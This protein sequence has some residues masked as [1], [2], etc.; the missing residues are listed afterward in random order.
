MRNTTQDL[1][2]P[3]NPSFLSYIDN[4]M[5]PL[6]SALIAKGY[7]PYSHCEG[8]T[9]KDRT[10][11]T[12]AFGKEGSAQKFRKEIYDTGLVHRARSITC[13]E[14]RDLRFE[15]IDDE[16]ETIYGLREKATLGHDERV[17][18]LNQIFGRNERNY[19]LTEVEV[20]GR[21][22]K[23]LSKRCILKKRRI[24]EITR[25]IEDSLDPFI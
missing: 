22:Y 11:F 12:V 1:V 23:E 14:H 2:S 15:T 13:D 16:N 9:I 19:F 7:L 4:K 6:L 24:I 10:F 17:K 8:H 21:G 3:Y 20:F 18:W 25:W 5:K